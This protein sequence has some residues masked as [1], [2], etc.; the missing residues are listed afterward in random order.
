MSGSFVSNYIPVKENEKY[1]GSIFASRYAFY[2]KNLNFVR[3]YSQ[4]GSITPVEGF[5]IPTGAGIK[6]ARFSYYGT[7][8][9]DA[10]L[11]NYSYFPPI[12]HKEYYKSKT[13]KSFVRPGTIGITDLS[14]ISHDSDTDMIK[15]YA[16]NGY[17]K[18]DGNVKTTT[19][20]WSYTDFIELEEGGRYYIIGNY[21][22][23]TAFYDEN[24]DF[25]SNNVSAGWFVVPVGVKYIRASWSGLD[26]T[27]FLSKFSGELPPFAYKPVFKEERPTDYNGEDISVFHKIICIGDSLTA[28]V[29]NVGEGSPSA[30]QQWAKYNYP[31]CL[32]KITGVETFEAGIGSITTPG[33]YEYYK[34]E[35]LSGFDCAI[36]QLGVN[37]GGWSNDVK[38]GYDNIIAKLRNDNKDIVIFIANIIHAVSYG[39]S[40]TAKTY[41][42]NLASYVA[43]RAET[44]T[45]LLDMSR[46]GHVIEGL[47]YNAGHLTGYGY[48]RL[49]AD[50]KAY[51]GWYMHNHRDDFR[52]VH[53][54][55]TDCYY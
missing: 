40:E 15:S 8:T 50:Y 29:F 27:C 55:G 31:T 51:I 39:N 22:G 41:N 46:Y 12:P 37:D 45:I 9:T 30:Q 25:V 42:E 47:A 24:R 54:I 33:W 53:F 21:P 48:W 2:D 3:G 18:A 36:I 26:K 43:N 11:N 23:Y 6:Y 20:S 32:K 44:N 34:N 4:D 28:G 38:D 49:A 7:D 19:Q 14:F 13:Q 35:D 52:F 16:K 1:F 5:T 10:W 17:I